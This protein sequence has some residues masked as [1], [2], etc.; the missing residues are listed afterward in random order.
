MSTSPPSPS[1]S[2][3]I[4]DEP[5]HLY[6][7]LGEVSIS[8]LQSLLDIQWNSAAKYNSIYI[9][10]GSKFNEA[11]QFFH[12]P[13]TI[14]NKRYLS[15]AE[16]Q[17]VPQFLREP[18]ILSI[19]GG[20]GGGGGGGGSSKHKS[21]RSLVVVLDDFSGGNNETLNHLD[22]PV[23]SASITKNRRILNDIIQ[24]TLL[25]M[26]II[27]FNYKITTQKSLKQCIECFVKRALLYEIPPSRLM[28]CN[29]VRFAHPNAMEM[30][31][32]EMIPSTIQKT[33]DR[34]QNERYSRCFYQWYG[35]SVYTYN[36]IYNY[37]SYDLHRMLNQTRL[38][39]VFQSIL[40]DTHLSH[41]NMTL[42]RMALTHNKLINPKIWGTF[43]EYNF[44]IC[45]PRT[46]G[47][48][49]QYALGLK[50]LQM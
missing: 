50:Y 47:E 31:F 44:D 30:N 10:F 18:N 20:G 6:E 35:P 3:S 4:I 34:S 15:N 46:D 41:V 43:C 7:L 28:F 19:S 26:D 48:P 11:V 13:S 23:E 36:L 16:F 39:H 45:A 22:V 38:V 2:P 49:M 40:D 12:Y 21:R 8:H 25:P 5:S 27:M 42:V 1:Y 9:S 17:M 33:L 37:K 24:S 14:Q 32:E 29:Y